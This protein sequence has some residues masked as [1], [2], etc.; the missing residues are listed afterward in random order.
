VTLTVTEAGLTALDAD[1]LHL[2]ERAVVDGVE[3]AHVALVALGAEQG[4]VEG[5]VD[6]GDPRQKRNEFLEVGVEGNTG[7]LRR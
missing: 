7:I 2:R 1:A 6:D 3:A 4:A 5:A